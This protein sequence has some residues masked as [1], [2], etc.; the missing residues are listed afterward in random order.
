MV[1]LVITADFE[2]V[3]PGSSPG[4]TFFWCRVRVVKEIDLKSIGLRPRRFEPCRHRKFLLDIAQ[5]VE[6]RT[7]VP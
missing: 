6:R 5:L 3:I 4:R 1:K 2:S 7:V